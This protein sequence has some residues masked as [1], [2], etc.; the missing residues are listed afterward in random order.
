MGGR[1]P[2]SSPLS[3]PLSSF[4]PSAGQ[5]E[6]MV[7]GRILLGLM[8]SPFGSETEEIV[9]FC[10]LTGDE[11]DGDA[12]L[13]SGCNGLSSFSLAA[14]GGGSLSAERGTPSSPGSKE[15]MEQ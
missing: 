13:A 14:N 1:N 5:N 7:V 12:F 15:R 4:C 3:A 6:A 11:R 2:P 8:E 10:D 9:S